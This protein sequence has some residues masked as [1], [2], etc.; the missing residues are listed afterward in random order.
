MNEDN[1][2]AN[3]VKTAIISDCGTYRYELTRRWAVGGPILTFVMLNP[4]TADAETDDPTI[5][6]C[7][8]FGKAWGYSGIRV[9]NLYAL[10]S[11]SPVDLWKASD[12]VGPDN[13]RHLALAAMDRGG[14]IIAAWGKNAKPD[15]IMRALELFPYLHCL[16]LT[17]D[18]K[19]YHPLYIPY[20]AVPFIYAGSKSL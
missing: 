7:I 10:R 8:G 14:T 11:K 18:G 3:P 4:S 12:P 6:K 17:N 13:D 2:W 5:R 20:S 19:P 9:V 16:R 1:F 15:R